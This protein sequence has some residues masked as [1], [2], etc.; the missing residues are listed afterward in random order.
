[1]LP[2]FIRFRDLMEAGIVSN[3]TTLGNLVNDEGFPAGTKLTS[4]QRVWTL[5]EIE[6]WL[7][8]R[9]KPAPLLGSLRQKERRRTKREQAERDGQAA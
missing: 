6:Q 9:Q 4:N 2:K 7:A 1:M 8:T 3:W 5:V